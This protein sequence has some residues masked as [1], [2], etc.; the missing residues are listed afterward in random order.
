EVRATDRD[1]QRKGWYGII[2]E[3]GFPDTRVSM[4]LYPTI[5]ADY[6]AASERVRADILVEWDD[7]LEDRRIKRFHIIDVI[8]RIA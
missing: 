7:A 4:I 5:D 2:R 3:E 1:W 6:L 8:E